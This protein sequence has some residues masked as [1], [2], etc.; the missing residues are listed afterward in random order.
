MTFNLA[1]LFE[2][3]A[4]VIGD[5]VA[6]HTPARR[7]TY[8]ALD[9]RANRLAWHLRRAGLGAGDHI[10]LQLMNGTEYLEAM[11]AAFK[12]SAVPINVN[13]RYVERELE[14]L[15]RNADL[16]ALVFHRRFAELVGA[17]TAATPLIGHLVHVDDGSDLA[18]PSGSID[19]ERALAA[20]PPTPDWSGRSGDDLYIAYTGGTTGLPKGVMW[21]HVD[22]F[23]GA[24]G[25][26]DPMLDKGPISDPE[27]LG[28]R[29]L[30]GFPMVQLYTP[31][32]VHVSAHWGAFNGFYAGAT[33]VLG[34]PGPLDPAEIWSLVE[35]QRANLLV[36]VGDAMLR[37]L[38][39]HYTSH[40]EA[41]DASSLFVFSSGGA[42]LSPATKRQIGELFPNAIVLD[43]FG[44]TETGNTATRAG[45]DAP[46]FTVDATTTVLDH[47]L[48]PVAPGSGVIGRL[49]RRG[50][51]PFGYYK[52]PEKTRATFAE[53][54][55]QRWVMPGDE[56]T[57]EADGTIRLLGRGSRCINTGGEKVFAEEVEAVLKGHPD[58]L[59]T[60]VVGVPDEQWGATVAAVVQTRS[61]RPISL[62]ELQDHA[63]KELAGYKL[64]RRLANVEQV[65]R[66][67]NGKPDYRWAEQIAAK[68]VA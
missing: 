13:Y 42:I 19:Y 55:G 60:L 26:G 50:H 65:M 48:V 29:V 41:I 34:S 45:I 37:P 66:A 12:L 61:G 11:L 46:T 38:L 18:L 22:L 43:V 54:D 5:R 15:Y 31:P 49:A 62:T 59:D 20:E 47:D 67:P 9:E 44:S 24:L 33:V 4:G 3:V 7:L 27:Q 21:R 40:R 63:R 30:A 6:V 68:A 8:A 51:V 32:L 23:F 53:I 25:G 56:A 2:R 1:E 39:D 64:P 52:D 57:V 35:Q 10:G 58:V 36:G 17:A 16:R 28:E 14:Y